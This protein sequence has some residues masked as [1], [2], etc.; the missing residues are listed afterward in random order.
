ME[1]HNSLFFS[2]LVQNITKLD[3][4][5]MH[6]YIYIYIYNNTIQ[7]NSRTTSSFRIHLRVLTIFLGPYTKKVVKSNYQR[8]FSKLA[9]SKD[10][11]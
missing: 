3:K 1:E 8:Q 6:Y 7:H 5:H 2:K 4:M 11:I 10:I 9:F